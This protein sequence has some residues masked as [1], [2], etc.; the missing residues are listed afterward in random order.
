MPS[1]KNRSLAASVVQPI[2]PVQ[3]NESSRRETKVYG[4]FCML[5]R[6]L[7][8]L[9]DRWTVLIIRDLLIDR[10]RFSDPQRR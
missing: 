10:R 6:A 5:A 9:D 7:E 4:H 3:G 1:T 8:Y 2:E